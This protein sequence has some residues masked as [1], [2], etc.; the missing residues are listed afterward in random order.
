MSPDLKDQPL[1][2]D[3]VKRAPLVQQIAEQLRALIIDGTIPPGT[4]LLQE[5]VAAELRVSRTPLREALRILEQ[6]GLV[7][8]ARATGTV[9]VVRLTPED[10]NHLYQLREVID[11]LAARLAASQPMRPELQDELRQ[12]ADRIVWSVNPFNTRE[13][14]EVHTA[15]HLGVVAASRNTWMSQVDHLVRISS[16]MLYPVLRT[17][18]ERM[19]A[20]AAEH[21]GILEAILDGQP[22]LAEELARDHIRRARQFWLLETSSL[23]RHLSP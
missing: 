14:L 23:V 3:E 15:F 21:V 13:F 4:P 18:T 8:V 17:G 22:E 16:H 6:D 5:K 20:S 2:L 11:G 12:L 19:A 7:R 9:E 10:V 1:K